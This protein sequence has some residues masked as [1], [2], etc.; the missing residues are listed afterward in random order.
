MS[1]SAVGG[2]ATNELSSLDDVLSSASVVVVTGPGGVG[3]TS[4]S[5]ALG[6]RAAL[7]HGKR[8]LVVTVDP[9]RRLADALGIHGLTGEAVIVPL[10]TSEGRL[11]VKMIDMTA[12]WGRIVDACAPDVPSAEALKANSLFQSL[13][14]RFVASHDYVALDHLYRSDGAGRGADSTDPNVDLVVIDTPPGQHALDILD[15]PGRLDR[16]LSSRLLR[17]LTAGQA[18]RFGNLTSRPFLAV[19]ERLLGDAFLTRIV[20]FFTLFSRLRPQLASRLATIES[21]MT[22]EDT[23]FVTVSSAEQSVLESA[24]GLCNQ[25]AQRGIAVKSLIVNRVQPVAEVVL[26]EAEGEG[27]SKGE[28]ITVRV[29]PGVSEGDLEGVEEPDLRRSLQLLAR[30]HPTFSTTF[31]G[32]PSVVSLPRRAEGVVGL[33]DLQALLHDG[34]QLA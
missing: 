15:A 19:A 16:F 1:E 10:P 17:W 32:S 33:E 14:T 13:T 31:S 18:G 8:V 3:K 30:P 5:A 11:W 22:A 24:A 7:K 4:V 9:A 2:D 25:A 29:G 20:E 23:A 12:E 28:G 26:G 34:Q 21:Q 6:V 27:E